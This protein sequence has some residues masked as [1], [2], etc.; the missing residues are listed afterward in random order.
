[1]NKSPGEVTFFKL[2]HSELKKS[3][4][5]FSRAQAEFAIRHE[6]VKDAMEYSKQPGALMLQDR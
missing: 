2:L 6:R 5:F 1:M 3:I 4:H